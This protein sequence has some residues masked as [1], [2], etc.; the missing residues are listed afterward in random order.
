[1][2]MLR[3]QGLSDLRDLRRRVDAVMVQWLSNLSQKEKF[4]HCEKLSVLKLL[5]G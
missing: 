5:L 2:E 4:S 1:M 3:R